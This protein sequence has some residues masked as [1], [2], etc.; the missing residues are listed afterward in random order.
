MIDALISGKLIRDPQVKTSSNGNPYVQFLMSVSSHGEAD[1]QVMSGIGFDEAVVDKINLLKKGDSL[2]V[3]GSLKQ[4]EWQDK[5]TNE[6]KHGLSITANQSLSL[7][8]IKKRK[9]KPAADNH[10]AKTSGHEPPP[11]DDPL[12]F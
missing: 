11:F 7:Y 8:D 3:V 5:N 9:P 12:D 4:T 2:C 6:L 1:T 10:A